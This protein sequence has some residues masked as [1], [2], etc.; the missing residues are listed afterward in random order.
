M[1]FRVSVDGLYLQKEDGSSTV[2]PAEL[3]D[4]LTENFREILGSNEDTTIP[5]EVLR[6]IEWI[7][8]EKAVEVDLRET[9]EL[10]DFRNDA[11]SL[12]ELSH[13]S[14][15]SLALPYEAPLSLSRVL[16]DAVDQ[17][18]AAKATPVAA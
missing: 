18:A 10:D 3:T 14:E 9:V 7:T 4:Q 6:N 17:L 15:K 2:A 13:A 8:D 16:V 5:A 12:V 1:T 11:F